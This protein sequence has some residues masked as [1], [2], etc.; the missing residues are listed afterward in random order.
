MTVQCATCA[1]SRPYADYEHYMGYLEWPD[2][3][4]GVAA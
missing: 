1:A 3:L 4:V 2:L